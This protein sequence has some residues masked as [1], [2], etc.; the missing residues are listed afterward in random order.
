MH[1]SPRAT[2]QADCVHYM[3]PVA[4]HWNR[5]LAAW[6]DAA[7]RWEPPRGCATVPGRAAAGLNA[8]VE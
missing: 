3:M 4:A 2:G 6:V 8:V 5:V 7:G 1:H